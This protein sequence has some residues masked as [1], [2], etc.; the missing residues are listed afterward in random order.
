MG[1]PSN[2]GLTLVTD[3]AHLYYQHFQAGCLVG[4]AHEE[5][6]DELVSV[7]GSIGKRGGGL[8]V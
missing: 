5:S 7:Q 2:K 6:C 4:S 3:L 1:C 8:A